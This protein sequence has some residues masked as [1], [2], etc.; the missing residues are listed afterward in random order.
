MQLEN[1]LTMSLLT[2]HELVLYPI[3]FLVKVLCYNGGQVSHSLYCFIYARISR[4]NSN[5]LCHTEPIFAHSV[6]TEFTLVM[7]LSSS[8]EMDR[9]SLLYFILYLQ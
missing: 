2:F 1:R 5:L 3:S 4:I 6:N 7:A 8:E 9:Y